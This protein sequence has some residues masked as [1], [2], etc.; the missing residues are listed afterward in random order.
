MVR[1]RRKHCF[2]SRLNWGL[3]A[4]QPLEKVL[5]LA[6]RTADIDDFQA[7][8]Y[9]EIPVTEDVWSIASRIIGETVESR[10]PQVVLVASATASQTGG[11]SVTRALA[12][13]GISAVP[14]Y[15]VGLNG[16]AD[17]LGAIAVGQCL[18]D[19]GDRELLILCADSAGSEH[20]GRFLPDNQG[21][22]TDGAAA[23][24]LTNARPESGYEV[25]GVHHV[26]DYVVRDFSRGFSSP[27]RIARKLVALRRIAEETCKVANLQVEHLDHVFVNNYVAS[28]REVMV[29]GAVGRKSKLYPAHVDSVGHCFS[30]D[31][32]INLG[33]A[34]AEGDVAIGSRS[35][36]LGTG[37]GSWIAAVVQ[38]L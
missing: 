30:A 4:A 31:P 7:G 11:L 36:V 26:A 28:A 19:S 6:K 16:C 5:T 13:A 10:V 34:M 32:L 14:I 22:L 20:S 17:A 37:P 2:L 35:L 33:S 8:G 1:A 29:R 24:L 3:G 23:C 12:G 25:L 38:R 27:D 18:V 21:I 9:R 15:S